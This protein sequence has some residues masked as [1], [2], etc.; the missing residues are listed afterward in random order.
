MK[1]EVIKRDSDGN[2]ERTVTEMKDGQTCTVTTRTTRDGKTETI[3]NT[4]N[5]SKWN[6]LLHTSFQIVYCQL[7]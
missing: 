7:K 4:C 2:E 5:N 3:E 1:R 6:M